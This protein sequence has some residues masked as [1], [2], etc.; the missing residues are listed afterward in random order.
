MLCIRPF[1]YFL[2]LRLPQLVRI[3]RKHRMPDRSARRSGIAVS[4][5]AIVRLSDSDLQCRTASV[6]DVYGRINR[7]EMNE[8]YATNVRIRRS[9]RSEVNAGTLQ[10][11]RLCVFRS[12]LQRKT[13]KL[14]TASRFFF[15]MRRLHRYTRASVGPAATTLTSNGI[16]ND[17]KWTAEA[18]NR[19]SGVSREET[20]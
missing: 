2:L 12:Q 16:L 13:N 10:R 3:R 8:Q 6:D 7:R 18:G 5:K 4:A 17:R 14:Y 19:D 9:R 15:P 1:L 11:R 20:L